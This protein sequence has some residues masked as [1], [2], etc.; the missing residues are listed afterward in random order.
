MFEYYELWDFWDL[1]E[2]IT[3]ILL[4]IN[5]VMIM[6]LV[7]GLTIYVWFLPL[8]LIVK[9]VCLPIGLLVVSLLLMFIRFIFD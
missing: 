5:I 7:S 8:P 2:L 9:A 4:V 3:K 6:V 1:V